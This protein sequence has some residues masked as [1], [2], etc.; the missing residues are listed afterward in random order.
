[1]RKLLLALFVL[2]TSIAQSQI[3]HLQVTIPWYGTCN[4]EIYIPAGATGTL[5]TVAFIPGLGEENTDVNGL[6][7][8]GPMRFI[9]D[10]GWRP[11]F[12]VMGIQ[13]ST[14]WPNRLFIHHMMDTLISRAE[15]HINKDR[16]TLTGLSAGANCI[17]DY[18]IFLY[19]NPTWLKPASLIPMSYAVNGSCLADPTNYWSNYLC[20]A[21][22][23]WHCTPSWGFCGTG[24]SFYGRMETFFTQMQ[25]AGWP[26]KKFTPY[27]G[28]H[29]GWNDYYNPTYKQSF[30]GVMMNI[31]EWGTQ[32]TFT[33]AG[34]CL[35]SL[36]VKLLSFDVNKVNNTAVLNWKVAAEENFSH[37]E[38]ERSGEGR[39]FSTFKS[40]PGGR[41]A[42]EETDRSPLPKSFYRLKMVDADG[43]FLYSPVK[44]ITTTQKEIRSVRA[45]NTAGQLTLEMTTNNVD[46]FI[47]R[48]TKKQAYILNI[49]AVDGSVEIRKLFI[50]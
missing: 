50:E 30:N 9:R 17:Y 48:L 22:E 43:T 10:N 37:Y 3:Q 34:V 21:D 23:P 35:Q 40:V 5:P 28:G 26:Q 32:S 46:A 14:G 13:P 24:D 31:Y 8:H 41:T 6:Y 12:I 42:Y 25:A 4:V 49:V 47:R 1:M 15:L 19:T 33:S 16:V 20:A 39:T 27:A 36:P 29:G 45:Y 44:V 7:V 11:P 2:M 18:M 38:I